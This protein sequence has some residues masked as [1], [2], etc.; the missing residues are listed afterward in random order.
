MRPP[1]WG[2]AEYFEKDPPQEVHGVL[3][4]RSLQSRE[5]FFSF[6]SNTSIVP[7]ITAYPHLHPLPVKLAV[8]VG[9]LAAGA[10][11]VPGLLVV[12]PD[13]PERLDHPPPREGRGDRQEG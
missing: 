3:A 5:R 11:D 13:A 8:V 9:L 6:R 2:P 4:M 10:D 7:I 1:P 12:G